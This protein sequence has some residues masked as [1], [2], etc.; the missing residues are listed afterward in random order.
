[1]WICTK[2]YDKKDFSIKSTD[3]SSHGRCEVCET[4]T[5]CYDCKEKNSIDEVQH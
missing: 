4:E 2:C 3:Y 5:L 1:M